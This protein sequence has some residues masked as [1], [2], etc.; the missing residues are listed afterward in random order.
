M[1]FTAKD[2]QALREKTGVGMMDCKKALVAS[3]G[4]MDKAIDFLREKGL[5]AA[6]KKASRIAA[7]GVVLAYYDEAAKV[8]VVIE[9]NSETDFVAKNEKFTDFVKAIAKTIVAENPADVDALNAMKL[10]GSDKTVEE[11][12]QELV[13]AIGENM[14]VRRFERVEGH[15]ATYIHGGG[16]VGVMVLF[17]TDDATAAKDEFKTMGKDVAMQ[18]AAMNPSYLDEASVPAEVIAHEKEIL[19][20]QIK[21]DPKMSSKP[22]KVIEGIIAG[23]I[24]KYYK[25]NCLVDQEF[26]KNGDF[27]VGGYIADVAKTLG[28]DIKAVKFIRYAK[29]EGLQKR[30][31]N[32]ADEVASMM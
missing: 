23:K 2:V 6:T 29:G 5:A 20:A 3:D 14:K 8:G 32:F 19:A 24:K 26:V 7:E 17:D 27:T 4:D 18:I 11:M 28:A 31:D 21:E 30:E 15:V 22:E 9:V 16:T 1:A 13:L 25:E 10:D 12:R